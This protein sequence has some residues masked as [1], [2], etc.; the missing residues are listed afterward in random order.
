MHRARSSRL[1]RGP[2]HRSVEGPVHLERREVPLEPAD[3]VV[4]PRRQ[5][6]PGDEAAVELWRD[7]I[8]ENGTT[9]VELASVR[10]AHT[11]RAS[12][13]YDD[14]AHRGVALESPAAALE[15]SYQRS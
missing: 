9:R 4:Q 5:V 8:S 6:V 13:S 1:F 3:V 12:V 15:P 7:D 11:D 2:R 10:G 14:L